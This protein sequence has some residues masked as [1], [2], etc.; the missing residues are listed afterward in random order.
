VISRADIN[1]PPPRALSSF[2]DRCAAIVASRSPAQGRHRRRAA[3]E[4]D[5]VKLAP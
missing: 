4:F 1:R 2:A 5:F 3:I